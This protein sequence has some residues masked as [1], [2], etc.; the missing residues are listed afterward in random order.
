[1]E[2]KRCTK[3]M[4]VK[5]IT[6]FNYHTKSKGKLDSVCKC[7]TRARTRVYREKNPDR[8]RSKNMRLRYGIELDEYNRLLR[9]QRNKCRICLR[10]DVKLVVDHCHDT[11][12]IRGLL[13]K[14]CNTGLGMFRDSLK[15]VKRAVQYL[16]R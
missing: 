15:H 11:G 14:H 13:C 12:K 5:P 6:E 8:I 9:A 3:C 2:S 7:C 1:M 16:M 4:V 10:D